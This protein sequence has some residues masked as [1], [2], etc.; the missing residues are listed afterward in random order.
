MATLVCNRLLY[1]L[2]E[3]RSIPTPH[4]PC[5]VR[6]SDGNLLHS[7]ISSWPVCIYIHRIS[8][9]GLEIHSRFTMP[10]TFSYQWDTPVYKG[11]TSFNT[12]L[13]IGGEFVDGVNG[14]TIGC[15]R[16]VWLWHDA[17]SDLVSIFN[18][19]ECYLCS[20]GYLFTLVLLSRR[21]THHASL[22]SNRGRCRPCSRSRPECIW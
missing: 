13:F 14:T 19:S 8:T 5:R 17:H 10:S 11:S 1:V 12:G 15:V 4:L 22:W 2:T 3:R 7:F 20:G 16:W 9:E 6:R 21:K 18:P